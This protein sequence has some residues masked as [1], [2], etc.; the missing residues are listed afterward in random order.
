M[1]D[2]VTAAGAGGPGDLVQPFALAGGLA[3][4]RLVRLGAALDTIL[5]PPHD[6]PAPVAHLLAETTIL[7]ATL[8]AA[9]KYDGVFTLQVQGDGPVSLLVADVTSAGMIRAHAR[10][11]GAVPSET[12]VPA[13]L[14][15]GHLAFTVDQGPD[16][17]RYQGIVALESDTLAGCVEDYFR[18]SEQIDTRIETAVTPPAAGGGW[19]GGVV[20]VQRMP[21]G[22]SHAPILL[23]DEAEEAWTRA[24]VLLGSLTAA[25]L[26]DP[27]LTPGRL[28]HRLYHGDGL[29]LFEPRALTAGCRCSREKVAAVLTSFP[30]SERLSLADEAGLIHATCEFC[31]R[32]H[33]FTLAELD[34]AAAG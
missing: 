14:G 5:G 6:Y 18:L 30:G 25:E 3:R 22:L 13:L 27:A 32:T 24:T 12:T 9:L 33:A 17:D 21:A 1:S 8:A 20:M 16:T 28:L 26:L 10:L 7:A 4:G 34:S 29:H 2:A 15:H 19:G 31:G 11:R 23:A